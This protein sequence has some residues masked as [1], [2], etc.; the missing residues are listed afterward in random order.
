MH[1]Y[2]YL[3]S[4]KFD[5]KITLH[6]REEKRRES[7]KSP[8][9]QRY[10]RIHNV[11]GKRCKIDRSVD[12]MPVAVLIRLALF[13]SHT[14]AYTFIPFQHTQMTLYIKRQMNTQ[15]QRER[16]TYSC[17]HKY[18]HRFGKTAKP[19]MYF[20]MLLLFEYDLVSNR[21]IVVAVISHIHIPKSFVRSFFLLLLFIIIIIIFVVVVISFS[22]FLVRFYSYILRFIR[23]EIIPFLHNIFL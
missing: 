8:Y 4:E 1:I 5:G 15:T 22:S 20:Y 9:V 23:C 19:N 13:I 6:R 10:A 12:A 18:S 16:H 21:T 11:I 7:K 17:T 14:H 3:W 2:L